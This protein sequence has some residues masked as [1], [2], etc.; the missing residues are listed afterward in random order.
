MPREAGLF[1]ESGGSVVNAYHILRQNGG[2]IPP[3]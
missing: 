1:E 3:N 2:N